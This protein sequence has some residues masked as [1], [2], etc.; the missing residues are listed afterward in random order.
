MNLENS[1]TLN[2]SSGNNWLKS[3][4]L[5]WNRSEKSPI[6]AKRISNII[7]FL[8]FEVFKYSCRGL[9]ENHK[10]LF[11]LLL[12]LKIDQQMG[13]VSHNEFQTLIKGK[14]LFIQIQAN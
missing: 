1:V 8:T 4:L 2:N 3:F 14:N 5:T 9:Y 7:E 12:A 10:F 11:T 13:N 6:P